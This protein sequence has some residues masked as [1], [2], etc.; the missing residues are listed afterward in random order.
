MFEL[1]PQTWASS[2][3]DLLSKR[4]TERIEVSFKVPTLRNIALTSPYVH[5]GRFATLEEDLDHYNQGIKT[6]S[7]LSPHIAEA[8]NLIRAA[9]TQP[10]LNLAEHEKSAIVAFLHTLTDQQFVADE[11]FSNP[12][13]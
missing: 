6:S 13:D 9:G 4:K 5:D 12:L 1:T 11:K 8:D 3:G 10:S 7:T 2:V